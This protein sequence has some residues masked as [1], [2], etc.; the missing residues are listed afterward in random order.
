MVE[1]PE[2]IVL[3]QLA[4]LREDMQAGFAGLRGDLATLT[5]KVERHG[6]NVD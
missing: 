5:E 3:K 1:E 2:N 6:A 4:L